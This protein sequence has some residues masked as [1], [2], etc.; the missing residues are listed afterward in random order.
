[1][2]QDINWSRKAIKYV[3]L[4]LLIQEILDNEYAEIEVDTRTKTNAIDE[5]SFD[6]QK[7]PECEERTEER[8]KSAPFGKS[9]TN[10]TCCED[11]ATLLQ[12]VSVYKYLG[13]IED[14]RR[15]PTRSSFEEV[16]NKLISRNRQCDVL[17]KNKIHLRPGCKERL[18]LPR[19][20]LGRGLNS[21]EV[22]SEHMLLTLGLSR[23]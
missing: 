17:V 12:G 2:Y 11:T 19:T 22:R 14:S 3:H 21:V 13:I 23:K 20:E 4:F 1:M 6:L 10:D 7:E 16:Q 9:A 18:Y 15:I 8:R 5:V